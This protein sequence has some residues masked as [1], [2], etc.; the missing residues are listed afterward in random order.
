[1]KLRAQSSMYWIGLNKEIEHHVIRYEPCQTVERSQK[2]S[3][4]Y[5]WK[6]PIG[7]EKKLG[8]YIFFQGGKWFMLI[9]E[10]YS[11][12]PIIHS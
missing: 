8:V 9:A 1:M 6:F 11:K 5:T 2:N 4:L 7:L 10:Y 3:Q 12:C